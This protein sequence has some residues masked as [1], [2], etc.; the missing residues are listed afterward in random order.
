MEKR[1][2][3]IYSLDKAH[4][5]RLSYK[6]PAVQ[7]IYRDFFGEPGSHKAHEL[8]HTHYAPRVAHR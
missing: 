6:N 5:I 8:L 3:S 1:I 4:R 7:D 2:R